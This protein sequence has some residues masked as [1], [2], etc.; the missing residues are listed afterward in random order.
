MSAEAAPNVFRAGGISYLHIPCRVP[1]RGA[2]F[3][4]AVFAWKI[5]RDGDEPAFADATG[6]VIGHFV[7]R[8]GDVEDGGIRPY[9]Y[10]ESVDDTLRRITE[11]GGEV[12]AAPRPEGTLSV[13]TFR[14]PEGNVIGVWTETA[15]ASSG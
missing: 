8:E 14:D 10:V 5:R 11:N 6:H 7:A 12:A 15:Q 3:Y 4:E 13:A 2:D 9:I 1:S